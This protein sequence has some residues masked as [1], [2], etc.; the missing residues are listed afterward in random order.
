LTTAQSFHSDVNGVW[1]FGG[2]DLAPGCDP[3]NPLPPFG[4]FCGYGVRGIN[5]TWTRVPEPSTLV[6]L[7]V[8]LAGLV[9]SRRR[10][11]S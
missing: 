8:G 4:P 3:A 5:G 10:R 7:G 11:I 9:F 2:E 1:R 6:L